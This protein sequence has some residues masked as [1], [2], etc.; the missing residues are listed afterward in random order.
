MGGDILE[1]HLYTYIYTCSAHIC[2]CM[3]SYVC[4]KLSLKWEEEGAPNEKTKCLWRLTF[5]ECIW[6]SSFKIENTIILKSGLFPIE[7]LPLT[8]GLHLWGEVRRA[9]KFCL[10][11]WEE[12]QR[13]LAMTVLLKWDA[14]STYSAPLIQCSTH[15]V[16]VLC[17]SV[18]NE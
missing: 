2:I 3:Y 1:I 13:G 11:R 5:I 9:V 8:H 18:S 10:Q 7:P 14:G 4:I 12:A 16:S 6:L 17:K 15:T